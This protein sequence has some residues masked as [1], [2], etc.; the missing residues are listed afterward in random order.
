MRFHYI[1]VHVIIHRMALIYKIQPL[2]PSIFVAKR[3][4]QNTNYLF[5]FYH[6]YII[7]YQNSEILYIVALMRFGRKGVCVMNEKLK[8]VVDSIDFYQMT[9]PEDA[10]ILIFDTEKVVAY[11]AGKTIDLKFKIGQT[12]EQHKNTVSVRAM[13]SGRHIREER[14]AEAYGFAYVASSTPIFDNGNVVGVVTGIISNDR[15]SHMRDVATELSSSVDVMSATTEELAMTSSD[16]SRRLDELSQFADSMSE[17]IQQINKIVSAVKDIAMH[18]KILG[19][20]ASI[21]AAR[22]GEHGKG[23]AVV[24]NEIQKMAENSTNSA[25]HIAKQLD[26]IKQSIHYINDTTT[27]V[28]AFT[29]QYSSSMHDINHAYSSLTDLGKDLLKLSDIAKN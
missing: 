14:S 10:A 11:N 6:S 23:F 21:E 7:T 4:L 22:S 1:Y 20:N 9:F 13:R 27:Q 26:N 17:D 28:A 2:H 8:N 16:V 19:L 25:D 29:Q 24:A 12:V 15:I 5:R 18:S 3:S